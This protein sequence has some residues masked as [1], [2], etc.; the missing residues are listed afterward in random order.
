MTVMP[1][2]RSESIAAS[3]GS[4][5]DEGALIPLVIGVTGHRNPAAE[6]VPELERAME[7][8][9]ARLDD[10]APNTP[11]V[12][13][14]PLAR[15]CDRIAARVALRFRRQCGGR[16]RV[17]A[18][19]PLAIDDYRRDFSGDADDAREFE[20]LLA[21]V[22]EWFEVPPDAR[23]D[24]DSSGWVAEGDLRDGCYRR[25][26][27]FIAVQS[28]L[29][30]AMW[31]GKRTGLV[32][33][34]GEVVDFCRG[35]RP[36]HLPVSVPYRHAELLL[37]EPDQTPVAWIPTARE[38]GGRPAPSSAFDSWFS[39]LGP[40]LRSLEDL[41]N[42]LGRVSLPL[43]LPAML[44]VSIDVRAVDAW[45]RM[46]MRFRLLDALAASE[47][48]KV[49]RGAWLIPTVGVLGVIAFQWFS[50]VGGQDPFWA[51]LWILLYLA[52]LLSAWFIQYRIVTAHR[53]E[54]L[55]V[56]SRALAEAMRVQLAWTGSGVRQI[57]PDLYQA[58]RSRDVRQLRVLLRAAILEV[59]VIGARGSDA[60]ATA[61]GEA[62]I[63]EQ[64]DYFSGPAMERRRARAMAWGRAVSVQRGTVVVLS[65][66]L[67]A[68]SVAARFQGK[69]A[70]VAEPIPWVCFSVAV[71]LACALGVSYWQHV[72]L[73]KEDVE[74]ARRMTVVYARACDR[75]KKNPDI[76][77][78]VIAASGKEAL[79]EHADWFARHL[80]RL[81]APDVG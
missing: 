7:Q 48:R 26:G 41:N 51:P 17:V 39:E 44:K 76:A 56:H 43:W 21:E 63:R 35:Q 37:A 31:D 47:K 14:S 58:R 12:L 10:E 20:S 24:R 19:L 28:Q 80:D 23:M 25:L 81:R 61:C 27:L 1:P 57:A 2:P 34:T 70:W 11:F 69:G 65:V 16:I 72:T 32:G 73:D 40:S 49:Q 59:A 9:L 6:S 13:L 3:P 33:G 38:S 77:R 15:G 62:W 66:L 74:V 64:F 45:R 79:D 5:S 71:A 42:R 36:D 18:P 22:D 67:L 8:V 68:L 60:P 30:I 50:G 75:L 4:V 29:M 54:W 52:L 78:E 55:F 53:S 46:S